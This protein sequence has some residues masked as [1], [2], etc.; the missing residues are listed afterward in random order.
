MI[1]GNKRFFDFAHELGER[2]GYG[3]ISRGQ[4]V[5]EAKRASGLH[6]KKLK[7][8]GDYFHQWLLW[9]RRPQAH[10]ERLL[11]HTYESGSGAAGVR[12][13]E[14]AATSSVA[15]GGKRT[16]PSSSTASSLAR[17]RIW[18]MPSSRGR[19][20]SSPSTSQ[21]SRASET[22]SVGGASAIT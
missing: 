18:R 12:A 15:E 14:S 8:L 5:S 1:I 3:N 21:A 20:G 13:I 22:D 11:S 17:A 6:G 4:F 16:L 2:H 7:R 9:N 19:S 10:A